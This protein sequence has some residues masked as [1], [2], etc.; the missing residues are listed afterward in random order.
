V[1]KIRLCTPPV[2]NLENVWRIF[3]INIEIIEKFRPKMMAKITGQQNR[4]NRCV[5][6]LLATEIKDS[7]LYSR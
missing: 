2:E 5:A 6:N 3:H 7:L 1:K 4:D